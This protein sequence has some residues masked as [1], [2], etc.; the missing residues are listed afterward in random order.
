M[1]RKQEYNDNLQ[2]VYSLLQEYFN[3]AM[4]NRLLERQDFQTKSHNNLIELLKAIK[5][6][7]LNSQET[8][9]ACSVITDALRAFLNE[10]LFNY[11]KKFK[12]ARDILNTQLRNEVIADK[13][14]ENITRIR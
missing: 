3:K 12:T 7:S 14:C 11:I 9:Y 4:Q 8:R 13:V 10:N 6:E 1:K 2:G 5:E